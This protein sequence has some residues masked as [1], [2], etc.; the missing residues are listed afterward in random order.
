MTFW[1]AVNN[2][3]PRLDKHAHHL[4]KRHVCM[5]GQ[6]QLAILALCCHCTHPPLSTCWRSCWWFCNQ[7]RWSC[8]AGICSSILWTLSWESRCKFQ[9]WWWGDV[10]GQSQSRLHVSPRCWESKSW[11]QSDSEEEVCSFKFFQLTLL[12]TAFNRSFIW[13]ECWNHGRWCSEAACIIQ[14]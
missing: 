1:S 7:W 12:L 14:S 2:M 8:L 9:E 13:C 10:S 6:H 11:L 3:Q 5:S 4:C